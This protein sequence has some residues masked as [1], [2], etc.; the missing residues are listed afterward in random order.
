MDGTVGGA[1]LSPRPPFLHIKAEPHFEKTSFIWNGSGGLKT[2][3][4]CLCER[5]RLKDEILIL[6]PLSQQLGSA[7]DHREQSRAREKW[8]IWCWLGGIAAIFFSF[9]MDSDL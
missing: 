6:L 1:A 7:P 9:E 2:G 8:R 3:V 5:V 4:S